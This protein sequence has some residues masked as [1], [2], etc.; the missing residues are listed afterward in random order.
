MFKTDNFVH[1]SDHLSQNLTFYSNKIK[2]T[3]FCALLTFLVSFKSVDAIGL[4][5]GHVYK[6]NVN[7]DAHLFEANSPDKVVLTERE[8]IELLEDFS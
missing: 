1:S 4:P 3:L 8:S 7:V 5:N 2:F 6:L